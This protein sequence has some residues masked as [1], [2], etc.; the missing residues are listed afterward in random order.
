MDDPFSEEFDANAVLDRSPDEP[1]PEDVSESVEEFE[2]TLIRIRSLNRIDRIACGY[3]VAFDRH[4]NVMVRDVDELALPGRKEERLYGRRKPQEDRLP[5]AMR[6]QIGGDWPLPIG[7]CRRLNL[8]RDVTRG[9][10]EGLLNTVT[11][12]ESQQ[13]IEP[14]DYT[15][16][17]REAEDVAYIYTQPQTSQVST[18]LTVPLKYAQSCAD[19]HHFGEVSGEDYLAIFEKKCSCQWFSTGR[20]AFPRLFL[21]LC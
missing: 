19:L 1:T 15:Q 5:L 16:V 6:W 12:G 8:Y 10:F 13:P 14:P 4:M 2:R 20:N 3:V 11:G 18:T 17:T 21:T 9:V 7:H